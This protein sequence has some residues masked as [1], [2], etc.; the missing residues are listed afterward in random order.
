MKTILVTGGCGFIGSHT[1]YQLLK[2]GYKV[3][4]IDS[5]INSNPESLNYVLKLLKTNNP[6]ISENLLFL[7]GDRGQ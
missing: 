3:V 4:V 5:C 2:L 6:L 1:V 7:K